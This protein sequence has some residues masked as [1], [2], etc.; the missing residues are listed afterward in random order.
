MIINLR[1]TVSVILGCVLIVLGIVFLLFGLFAMDKDSSPKEVK[2]TNLMVL[3]EID[4][5]K[6]M[7]ALTYDDG[8]Y[9]PVTG[10]IL[11]ALKAVNGRAT[12]FVVGDRLDSRA[13]T[14]RKIVE[15]N[16]EIG[17]HTYSHTQL[18]CVSPESAEKELK[19][20]DE[21]VKELTGYTISLIRP[22]A[23]CLNK[24]LFSEETRPFVLWSIDTMDWSHQNAEKT[25]SR[26]LDNVQDGDIILMHDLFF[27]TADASEI[28]IPSLVA[29]NFQLVTV[30]ELLK[31]RQESADIIVNN[32]G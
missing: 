26:V 31:Y 12:F 32:N 14:L 5:D 19:K 7:V 22:P 8:P 16:C 3:G 6:P 2:E 23:G 25:V 17:N 11:E 20:T 1:K 24:K 30:S 29:R 10:R 15:Y 13:D 27:A 4:P 18:N 9:A 21:K 28:L